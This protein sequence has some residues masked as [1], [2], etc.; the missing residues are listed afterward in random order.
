M[1]KVVFNALGSWG[2]LFPLLPIG[3]EMRR[4]GHEVTFAV[5]SGFIDV[6]EGEGLGAVAI[7]RR[8]TITDRADDARRYDVRPRNP[9]AVKRLWKDFVLAELPEMVEGLERA[10]HG[11]DVLVA[12]PSQQ[13]APIVHERTGIP[14]V[15][16]SMILG[17]MPSRHTLPQGAIPHPFKGRIG[18]V[19]NAGTWAI[20]KAALSLI[21][22]SS[23]NAA[24][25]RVGARR[26]RNTMFKAL[27]PQLD[28]WL[29][30]PIYQ[31]RPPD[32]PE[33]VRQV[34]FTYFDEPKRWPVPADLDAFLERDDPYVVFTLGFSAGMNP[35]A[36]FD[37][38]KKARAE[39]GTRALFLGGWAQNVEPNTND[40][41]VALTFAPLSRLLPRAAAIVHAGG[42]GTTSHAL[43]HGVPQVVVP[44]GFDQLFHGDSVRS[45]GVGALLPRRRLSA[46]RLANVLREVTT[47]EDV[48]ESAKHVRS[49]LVREGDGSARACDE[50]E[51][52]L[53]SR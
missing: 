10:C 47:S 25:K 23:T 16:A 40:S 43:R 2:D 53:A 6:V 50:I 41:H 3:K 4:R 13:A 46:D 51:A 26:Q 12:H 33:H 24:R 21:L 52:F 22:D 1:A 28:L 14:W 17:M 31:P 30:S 37:F 48:R 18:R 7:A 35:G 36:F 45:L 49:E 20:G 8:A 11:A 9:M 38:A 39:L 34:G 27:S 19:I 5:P 32:W 29:S 42:Y 44:W 15:T